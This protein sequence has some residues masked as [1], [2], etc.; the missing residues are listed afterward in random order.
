MN[1]CLHSCYHLNFWV[2]QASKIN[3]GLRHIFC[4][5]QKQE[6]GWWKRLLKAEGKPP[7]YLKVDW[8]KWVDEDEEGAE[9]SKR[10]CSSN[11]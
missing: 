7:P 9:G 1:Y 10:K 3:V 2:E 5:I 6:K 4:I 11:V 8:N